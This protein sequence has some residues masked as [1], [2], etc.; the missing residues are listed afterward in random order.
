MKTSLSQENREIIKIDL[1]FER[2]W[3]AKKVTLKLNVSLNG[4]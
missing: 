4:E 2:N 1:G 3:P